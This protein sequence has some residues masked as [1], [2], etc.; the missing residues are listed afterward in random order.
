MHTAI[1]FL[2]C[3]FL[4]G[5]GGSAARAQPYIL[6]QAS[7]GCT[8]FAIGHGEFKY[9]CSEY[10]VTLGVLSEVRILSL[11]REGSTGVQRII[12]E[13]KDGKS[14]LLKNF[15]SFEWVVKNCKPKV[16]C[17]QSAT[18]RNDEAMSL[19]CPNGLEVYAM[20][21]GIFLEDQDPL[22]TVEIGEMAICF[23]DQ[24]MEALISAELFATDPDAFLLSPKP[25]ESGMK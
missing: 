12:L 6:S 5:A 11:Q 10:D 15:L 14:L 17:F 22:R 25:A 7:M 4:A 20:H 18:A 19:A 1:K 16:S 24:G 3:V 21:R 8:I 2:L 23:G 9:V 13:E